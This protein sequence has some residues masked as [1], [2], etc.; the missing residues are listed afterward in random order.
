MIKKICIFSKK[1]TP[2]LSNL[3]ITGPYENCPEKLFVLKNLEPISDIEQEI[4][5]LSRKFIRRCCQNLIALQ[6]FFFSQKLY[7]FVSR[8]AFEQKHFGLLSKVFQQGCQK[9][10]LLIH[11]NH[12]RENNF[13]SKKNRFFTSFSNNQRNIF[14]FWS[15]NF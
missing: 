2:S 9:F 3:H 11:G 4:I 5:A 15:E 10:I 12:L 7:F 8:M 14:V 6:A 1:N 13:F